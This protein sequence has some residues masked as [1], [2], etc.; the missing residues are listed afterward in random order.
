MRI[1]LGLLRMVSIVYLALPLFIFIFGWI[2]LPIAI[3]L[4]AALLFLVNEGRKTSRVET[5]DGTPQ[6]SVS[7]AQ[8]IGLV[9]IVIGWVLTS[10]IGG[11]GLQNGDY[12]KHNSI[13]KTLIEYEWPPV[14][15]AA[16]LNDRLVYY[17]GYYL[18]PAAIGKL[19]GWAGAHAAM[20]VWSIGGL[21]IAS[22]WIGVL[23]KSFS[24][25]G[26][27]FFVLS[28]GLD[29]VGHWI[30]H[31][32]LPNP[33]DHIEW[34]AGLF[35]YSSN[36]TLLYWV[37]QHA[38]AGWIAG[39]LLL[40]S[41][42]AKGPPVLSGIAVLL[43]GFW[44][45]FVALGL[46][47][48][49]LFQFARYVKCRHEIALQR[50]RLLIGLCAAALIGFMLANFFG[51]VDSSRIPQYFVPGRVGASA[52]LTAW[53]LFVAL[54]FAC[55]FAF[56]DRMTP[57]RWVA[58]VSLLLIPLF[59]VG[60]YNDF[61]MRVSIPALYV[62][63]V[64]VIAQLNRRFESRGIRGLVSPLFVLWLLGTGASITELSRS[65]ST[66]EGLWV[67]HIPNEGWVPAIN[68]MGIP[69]TEFQYLGNPDS[70]FFRFLA[71]NP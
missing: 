1:D 51:S 70:F 55:F 13:L 65:V 30:R 24:P 12:V 45:P 56:I 43:T 2:K 63:W 27:F 33:T 37:P 34:W 25:R 9:A 31:S 50:N 61:A 42:D 38:L 32:G 16:G 14:I 67:Q 64:S 68:R 62:L 23:S 22:L 53:A 18:V 71:K 29:V 20:F 17:L 26:V 21:L 28:G 39:P 11:F 41:E 7:Q 59:S 15:S 69:G 66:S 60:L 46:T 3:V 52:F 57:A 6:F 35:Q 44:S 58:G 8:G 47:P 36:T 19:L 49:W 54:E 4:A 48:F 10:G 40:S 5:I